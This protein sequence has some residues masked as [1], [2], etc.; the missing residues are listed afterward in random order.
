MVFKSNPDF[1]DN[2]RALYEYMKGLD[3]FEL[4]WIV[5][6]EKVRL[7]LEEQGVCAVLEG[8]DEAYAAREA[9]SVLVSTSF[10]H[11]LVKRPDQLFVSTW[12]GFPLKLI[13]FFESAMASSDESLELRMTTDL[14]DIIVATSR[15]CQMLMAGMFASDPRKVLITGYPRVDMMFDA[16]GRSNLSRILPECIEDG[17]RLLLYMP[18]VRRGL[19]DEGDTFQENVFNYS[20]YDP[21]LLDEFLERQNAY[22]I[23][24]LHFADDGIIEKGRFRLPKRMRLLDTDS[25]TGKLL[26]VYHILNA[27]D[28][29]IA[30]YSSIFTEFML[31]DRP[32]VFSC[33]DLERYKADR[34]FVVDDPTL[35]MPGPIARTQAELISGIES[36]FK[37]DAYMERRNALKTYF[38]SFAD[39]RS[40]MRLSNAIE[41]SL[42]KRPPDSNKDYSWQF[43]DSLSPLSSYTGRCMAQFFFDIG[44]GINECDSVFIAYDSNDRDDMG[45]VRL[46]VE[47]PIGFKGLARFDPDDS[48]RLALKD[49]SANIRGVAP[50]RVTHNGVE[51]G[52]LLAFASHDP[53]VFLEFEEDLWSVEGR[54]VLEVSFRPVVCAFEGATIICESLKELSGFDSEISLLQA[55]LDGVYNSRSW[56]LTKP[57]RRK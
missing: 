9:A 12:H 36:V 28:V 8:T 22:L 48:N 31:L 16:D 55:E 46:S 33:P 13:G 4:C 1:S 49:F 32:V 39:N 10:D 27:F 20:D 15:C 11:A 51:R 6:K 5:E 26:T 3:S 44:N 38:H 54:L 45:F 56:R 24:K 34:G 35:L 7:L 43:L 17:A 50:Y 19:K 23:A 53:Y 18:T 52:G 2:P 40:S 57:F 25:L 29:L 14:S 37:E 41:R 47:L 30:D 21:D 42:S